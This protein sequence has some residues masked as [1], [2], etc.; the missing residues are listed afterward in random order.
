MS[1]KENKYIYDNGFG[2]VHYTCMNSSCKSHRLVRKISG[3]FSPPTYKC[4]DCGHV[5]GSPLWTDART[6]EQKKQETEEKRQKEFN[7][8]KKNVDDAETA[9]LSAKREFRKF[10]GVE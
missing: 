6:N 2:P 1:K 8:L 4:D 5:S 10:I 7:R 3:G 9:F